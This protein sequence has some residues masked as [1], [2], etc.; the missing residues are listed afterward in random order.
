MHVLKMECIGSKFPFKSVLCWELHLRLISIEHSFT[1]GMKQIK[2][3]G[4]RLLIIVTAKLIV[5]HCTY[6]YAS[7]T[8][9]GIFYCYPGFFMHFYH[10]QWTGSCQN[11]LLMHSTKSA[12]W[13][14]R[15]NC[16]KMYF[17]WMKPTA[18]ETYQTSF[19]SNFIGVKVEVQL[20]IFNA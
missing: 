14:P 13:S 4:I 17:P 15:T 3:Y 9:K 5:H 19:G 18:R 20:L 2:I 12:L 10:P 11:D 6:H 7:Q 16:R 8:C 1:S